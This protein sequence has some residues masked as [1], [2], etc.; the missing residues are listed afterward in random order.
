MARI[1]IADDE[2]G[3][4]YYLQRSIQQI[5]HVPI[6]ASNGKE[7]LDIFKSGS[8][9]LSIVDINMPE[10][11]GLKF[12]HRAKKINPAAVVIIITGYPSAESVVETIEDDG[13]TY[14]TKPIDMVRLQDLINRGLVM[15]DKSLGKK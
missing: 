2:E 9:D 8:I 14:M 6:E 3:V 4:R 1:L 12:L 11:D 5:G 7:A 13:Y 10:M 15:R